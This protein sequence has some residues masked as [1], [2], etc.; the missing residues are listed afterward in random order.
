MKTLSQFLEATE[1]DLKDMGANEKQVAELKRRQAERKKKGIDKGFTTGDD[2]N[3]STT[4][5]ASSSSSGST[6]RGQKALP[7]ASGG[8]LAT[9]PADVGSALVRTKQ[10]KQETPAEPKKKRQTV[11]N[12]MPRVVNP[13]EKKKEEKK[14]K[15]K[16]DRFAGL[17]RR[18]GDAIGSAGSEVEAGMSKEGK[19]LEGS[20]EI[21]RGERK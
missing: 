20:K 17:R 12:Y 6:R 1:R 15:K 21:I 5:P 14:K 10:S 7:P 4:A 8:S 19:G 2:R 13:E 9:R 16:K 3:K 18:A 11:S